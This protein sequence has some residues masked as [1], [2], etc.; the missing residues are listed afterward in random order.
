LEGG[1]QRPAGLEA[2]SAAPPYPIENVLRRNNTIMKT[3]LLKIAAV[4]LVAALGSAAHAQVGV[5]A[6]ITFNQPG[7]YGRVDIGAPGAVGYV[8]PDVIY[9]QP[10]VIAPSRVAGYQRPIYLYVPEAYTHD[11]AHHCRA[12]GACGQPVYFVRDQWVRDRYVQ[13]Y[14]H[15]HRFDGRGPD[16]GGWH[17]HGHDDG[18]D[19]DDHRDHHDD[20][21]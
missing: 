13:H 1:G 4:S 16:H 8:A 7:V 6:S 3:T 12:Y 5:G 9:P 18:H 20:R 15:D 21:R 11:W 19:R 17:D 14:P 10:V 2:P